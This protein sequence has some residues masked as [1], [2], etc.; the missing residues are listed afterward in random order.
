[1]SAATREPA[2]TAEVARHYLHLLGSERTARAFG[3]TVGLVLFSSLVAPGFAGIAAILWAMLFY[4]LLQW[5]SADRRGGLDEAMPLGQVRHHLVRAACGAAWAA[6]ALS[7][8]IVLVAL[9]FYLGHPG[10]PG[11]WWVPPLLLGFGLGFYLFGMAAWLPGE[12]NAPL[13]WA[14]SAC[15]ILPFMLLGDRWNRLE[16]L[17]S[18]REP[19]ASGEAWALAGAAMLWLGAGA[20]AAWLS[21]SAPRWL[22][23]LQ[24]RYARAVPRKGMRGPGGALPL[25]AVRPAAADAPRRPAPLHRVLW[26]EIVLLIP[27]LGSAALLIPLLV[28]APTATGGERSTHFDSVGFFFTGLL[29]VWWPIFVWGIGS[30]PSR[31]GVE[32]LPVGALTQRL[33]RLAAGAVWLEVILLLVLAAPAAGLGA[34]IPPLV[35]GNATSWAALLADAL[36]LYLLASLPT[37]L[38]T[39]HQLLLYVGWL[40][41]LIPMLPLVH[42]VRPHARFSLGSALSVAAGNTEA[43]V[44]WA[45]VFTAAAVLAAA[46]G[47]AEERSARSRL[48]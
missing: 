40:V 18:L 16:R 30:R 43:T 3:L 9:L 32:P 10:R 15:G 47:V 11:F 31:R 44:L 28:A 13:A 25:P 37:L 26:C 38:W 6:A 33:V 20:A 42:S 21:A 22:P 45:A 34:W 2:T 14:V 1:V 7:V 48:D 39:R 46:W 5:G 29:P 27:K 19:P 4:P 8:S 24:V 17:F 23:R 35:P 12:T 36:L 41:F